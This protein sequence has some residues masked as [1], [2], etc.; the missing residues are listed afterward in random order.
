MHIDTMAITL[1][2]TET[3]EH[4]GNYSPLPWGATSLAVT[5]VSSVSVVRDSRSATDGREIMGSGR[6]VD[7]FFS[8][9]F[10]RLRC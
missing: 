1:T 2:Y 3:P 9:P 6:V 10:L 8:M 5:V 4:G 7:N